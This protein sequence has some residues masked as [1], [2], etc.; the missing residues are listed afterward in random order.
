MVTL[1]CL[2]S[3]SHKNDVHNIYPPLNKKFLT[4]LECTFHPLE[5]YCRS[6][7][8]LCAL[9]AQ[10][11]WASLA[12]R[13]SQ[14]GLGARVLLFG[15]EIVASDRYIIIEWNI[16]DIFFGI[17]NNCFPGQYSSGA[18]FK[19]STIFWQYQWFVPKGPRGGW[20]VLHWNSGFSPMQCVVMVWL[21]RI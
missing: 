17:D 16:S 6:C 3:L 7:R 10:A 19:I 11:D 20:C 4:L 8:L 2:L 18:K 13:W 14:T 9:F 21:S 5:S 15:G 1:T 12:K